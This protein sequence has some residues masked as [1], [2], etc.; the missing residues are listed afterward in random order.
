MFTK[1]YKKTDEELKYEVLGEWFTILTKFC[2]SW[3]RTCE[4]LN[5][6]SPRFNFLHFF[7]FYGILRLVVG[8]S[9][10]I[11]VNRY[12]YRPKPKRHL[13]KILPLITLLLSHL[14]AYVHLL[15]YRQAIELQYIDSQQANYLHLIQYREPKN[16]LIYIY[17]T[18][19]NQQTIEVHLFQYRQ[20][21]NNR[22]TL[23]TLLT[24]DKQSIYTYY[25]INN[26]QT[27]YL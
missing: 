1:K 4:V 25:T 12:F 9:S 7:S 2:N 22:T 16:Q 13:T 15:L 23:T 21:K 6:S 14:T 10:I 20:L 3:N 19:D 26:Q 11:E 8:Y 18:I 5:Q 24:T 17:Y 27:K